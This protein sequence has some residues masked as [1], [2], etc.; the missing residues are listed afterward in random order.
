MT[1]TSSPPVVEGQTVRIEHL[2][3]KLESVIGVVRQLR[4]LESNYWHVGVLLENASAWRRIGGI[5]VDHPQ[6]PSPR[7]S[8]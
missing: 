1:I 2:N 8:P 6:T 4:H 3:D 5:R 7:T